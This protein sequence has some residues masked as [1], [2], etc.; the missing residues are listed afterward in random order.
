M[1]LIQFIHYFR[2]NTEFSVFVNGAFPSLKGGLLEITLTVPISYKQKVIQHEQQFIKNEQQPMK[3]KQQVIKYE[4]QVME[5]EQ[6][7]IKHEC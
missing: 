6:Q 2:K 3:Y 7:V 5:H 4:L 1:Q